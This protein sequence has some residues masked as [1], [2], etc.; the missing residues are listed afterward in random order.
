MTITLERLREAVAKDAAIR[1]VQRLQ[2]VGGPGDKIFPPTYPPSDEEKRG[3]RK[4]PPRHVFETRRIE[5]KNVLCVL[6]DSVQSQA[7]RLEEGLKAARESGS[8]TFPVIAVE[9][10]DTEIPDI[11]QITTLDAPHR[12]FDAIMRDSQLN[13]ASFWNTEAG[14]RLK[15][16]KTQNARAVYDL[17]PTALLFGAWNSTGE[18]G[19]LG[20]KFPRC[21]VSEIIGVGVSTETRVDTRTGGVLDRPSGQRTGSR[22]DPLGIRSGVAV[23]KLPDGDWSLVF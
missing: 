5:G 11:G 16:A 20:A 7:N 18:G 4:A 2:P 21:V 12:V 1:R 17:S 19:G 22:I 23:Y 14:K 10:A 8:V 6:I 9:F 13:G 3:N 15:L